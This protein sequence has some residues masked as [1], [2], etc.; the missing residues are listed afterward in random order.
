MPLIGFNLK[1]SFYKYHGTGNDFI[2]VDNRDDH[3]NPMEKL[4]ADLCHRR[5]GIG[6]DGLILLN[7]ARGF[8][9]GMKY[10]NS[11]GQ[12]STMCGNGGRCMVAF[13]DFLSLAGK[14]SRFLASDGE[15]TGSV[16]SKEGNVYHVS[17]SMNDVK[18]YQMLGKDFI[19][20]TGS[21]HLIRFVS[22]VDKVDVVKEGRAVRYLDDFQ[23]GGI[24]V[25]FVED[26]GGKIF[27]RTYERGVEDETLSCGTGVTAS[28]LAYAA[29]R[30]LKEGIIPVITRGG[31]LKL[32]FRRVGT[33]FTGIFLEGPAVH[34]YNGTINI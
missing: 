3:F 4:I 6:A 22:D 8:D 20:D 12:E 26:Q 2:L 33:V 25:N 29:S 5:F 13:A 30:D 19:L 31:S 17:L 23:P 14:S 24:N 7:N 10:Y 1:L 16:M 32:H 18:G 9:F 11:D 15:H 34:V 21:P 28:S 27:V